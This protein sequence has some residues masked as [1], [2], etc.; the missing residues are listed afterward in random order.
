MKYLSDTMNQ[1]KKFRVKNDKKFPIFVK[2][3]PIKAYTVHNTFCFVS[4][5]YVSLQRFLVSSKTQKSK[6]FSD[7]FVS[8]FLRCGKKKK[9]IIQHGK[10]QRLIFN[11]FLDY[12]ETFS[13]TYSE[14]NYFF[15]F[16]QSKH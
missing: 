1:M 4:F 12:N 3:Y 16:F 14:Y 2:Y 5:H 7:L 15:D 13:R 9:T 11:C 10:I 8:Q 6:Y